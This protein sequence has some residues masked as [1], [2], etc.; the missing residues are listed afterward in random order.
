MT[1]TSCLKIWNDCLCALDFDDCMY[2]IKWN[3]Y[4]EIESI[5]EHKGATTE[6]INNFFKE[7]HTRL[8]WFNGDKY[9]T[10]AYLFGRHK[11][12]KKIDNKRLKEDKV[13]NWCLNNEIPTGERNRKLLK[14]LAI[15]LLKAPITEQE[16]EVLASTIIHNCKDKKLS[17]ITS[18]IEYFKNQE[19]PQYNEHEV[20]SWSYKHGLFNIMYRRNKEYDRPNNNKTNNN[21][22]TNI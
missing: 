17:E 13:L 7:Y 21:S 12:I 2:I 22:K 16:R 18:W 9:K 11:H 15:M 14:N 10:R 6:E 19:M 5:L 4:R 3:K 8:N 20:D 1:D